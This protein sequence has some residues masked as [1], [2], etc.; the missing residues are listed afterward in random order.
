MITATPSIVAARIT[1][2]TRSAL[3]PADSAAETGAPRAARDSRRI[4]S[5]VSSSSMVSSSSS[6]GKVLC[7]VNARYSGHRKLGGIMHRACT[8]LRIIMPPGHDRLGGHIQAANLACHSAG[9]HRQL[10]IISIENQC[11]TGYP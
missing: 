7:V 5:A 4:S 9:F 11:L 10:D 6:G 8:A 1:G 2:H 3:F